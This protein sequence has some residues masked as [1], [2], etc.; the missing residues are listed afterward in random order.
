MGAGKSPRDSEIV[1]LADRFQRL[2]AELYE[3]AQGDPEIAKA[4]AADLDE[5]MT[6]LAN[7][8]VSL[9]PVVNIE[10]WVMVKL[11][12]GAHIDAQ[13]VRDRQGV[14]AGPLDGFCRAMLERID[15]GFFES[16]VEATTM[17]TGLTSSAKH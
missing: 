2:M 14:P 17:E 6:A 16:M 13:Q 7:R 5:E 4:K 8:L 15:A 1:R 9:T 3:A 10:F 12:L 11:A